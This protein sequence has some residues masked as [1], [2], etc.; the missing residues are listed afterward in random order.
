[1]AISEIKQTIS[2]SEVRCLPFDELLRR[3]ERLWEDPQAS[4]IV[5]RACEENLSHNQLHALAESVRRLANAV[6]L[7]PS[8]H[9]ASPD[10]A[11]KRMLARMPAEIAAPVAEQWLEH[12]RKFRRDIAYSVLRACGLTATSGVRLLETFN[13]T[14]DQECLK[15]IARNPVAIGDLNVPALIAR[16]EDEYWQMRLVQAALVA[17][18]SK[19]MPLAES[20]PREFLHS[21]G[22]LKDMT[23]IPTIRQIFRQHSHDLQLLSLYA[24]VLGQLSERE[25]LEQLRIHVESLD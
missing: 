5:Y 20:H 19:A 15:L 14:G 2:M 10:R 11:V 17:N 12:R 6:D 22:R 13:R 1:M 9:K 16:T 18:R 8:A 7:L 21:V 24:W 3:I 23:L 4:E 25:V